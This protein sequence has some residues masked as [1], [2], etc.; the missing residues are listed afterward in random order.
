MKPIADEQLQQAYR[1]AMSLSNDHDIAKDIVHSAYIKLLESNDNIHNSQGYLLRC[2]RNKF[3]DQKRFDNRWVMVPEE[4]QD[5]T[6]DI[7][8]DTLESTTVNQKLLQ[9]LWK[10]LNPLERELLYLWAIEEYTIDEI[11]EL[12]GT[13]RGTL[14]SRIHRVRKKV[15]NNQ[16]LVEVHH[17]KTN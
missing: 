4:N 14:L 6:C 17:G 15:A 10:E 11:S 3:I 13:S 1:Y 9:T 2:I 12:T 16:S 8:F 5:N 7:G